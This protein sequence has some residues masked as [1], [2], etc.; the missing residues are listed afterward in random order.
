MEKIKLRQVVDGVIALDFYAGEVS[1]YPDEG[2][3]IIRFVGA[4]DCNGNDIYEG[5]ILASLD[6]TCT[7]TYDDEMNCFMFGVYHAATTQNACDYGLSVVS[8]IHIKPD[9]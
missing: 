2:N 3:P 4:K 6:A 8:N 7:A 5:D 1:P 9:L